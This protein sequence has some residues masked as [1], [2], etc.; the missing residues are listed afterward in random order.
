MKYKQWSST[1]NMWRYSRWKALEN[2]IPASSLHSHSYNVIQL[3]IVIIQI[4]VVVLGV[5]DDNVRQPHRTT[6]VRFILTIACIQLHRVR[7][8][9]LTPLLVFAIPKLQVNNMRMPVCR[10]V[11]GNLA[12]ST[13]VV[14][15]SHCHHSQSNLSP[16]TSNFSCYPKGVD[17]SQWLCGQLILV[18]KDR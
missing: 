2:K 6:I 17:S 18:D 16:H 1:I 13:T 9:L 11:C 15:V 5:Y 8:H 14:V 4:I 10:I 12:Q 3:C 7:R